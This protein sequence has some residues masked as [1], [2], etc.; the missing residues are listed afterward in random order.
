MKKALVFILIYLFQ[1]GVFAQ[2][3]QK[4]KDDIILEKKYTIPITEKLQIRSVKKTGKLKIV[5]LRPEVN[6]IF[7]DK[8]TFFHKLSVKKR[9]SFREVFNYPVLHA[10]LSGGTN[11]W[12]TSSVGFQIN[13][14]K[15][16]PSMFWNYSQFDNDLNSEFRFMNFSGGF[17]YN[18]SPQISM[19]LHVNYEDGKQNYRIVPGVLPAWRQSGT[20]TPMLTQQLESDYSIMHPR[21]GIA[22]DGETF[23]GEVQT[24]YLDL[25]QNLALQNQFQDTYLNYK[26]SVPFGGWYLWSSGQLHAVL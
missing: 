3:K 12:L 7:Y 20:A 25:K 19:L 22:W 21:F 11:A 26:M 8:Q 23:S 2:Q 18:L 6:P 10:S 17:R 14:G 9:K 13:G 5:H 24:G 15:I 1:L 16:V 4:K